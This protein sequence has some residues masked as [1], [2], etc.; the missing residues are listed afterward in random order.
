M[1]QDVESRYRSRLQPP[2]TTVPE[3]AKLTEVSE[4]IQNA[5]AQTSMA[6]P[7]NATTGKKRK[8]LVEAVGEYNRPAPPAPTLKSQGTTYKAGSIPTI[9]RESST[10]SSRS[11]SAASSRNTSNGSNYS[12][13]RGGSR[14]QLP[15]PNSSISIYQQNARTPKPGPHRPT[16]SLDTIG[17]KVL[18]GNG[19]ENNSMR[20]FL[21]SSS[22]HITVRNKIPPKYSSAPTHTAATTNAFQNVTESSAMGRRAVKR[23]QSMRDISISTRLGALSLS[24]AQA[25]RPRKD[26]KEEEAISNHSPKT[27]ASQIPKKIKRLQ[28]AI[29][30]P[31][32][33][34]RSLSPTKSPR[35]RASP[36]RGFLTIESN[37]K[38]ADFDV[39]DRL[40]KMEMMYSDM[41]ASFT[42]S[43]SERDNL[44]ETMALLIARSL[45]KPFRF[46]KGFKLMIN[47][48]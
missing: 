33:S 40:D 41:K 20:P 46:R 4:S 9:S 21:S 7:E 30:T 13:S 8:A 1:D 12:Q 26:G 43:T 6:P 3:S 42:G 39:N 11:A 22:S 17:Q 45:Q 44:K 36:V 32:R 24:D 27:P 29:I 38:C 14:Y 15:R 34:S 10:A 48:F 16:S 2:K 23:A 18:D 19:Q 5:R 35:K 31:T 37:V 25:F 47:R 28:V